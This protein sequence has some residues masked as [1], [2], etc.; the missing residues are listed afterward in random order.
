MFG[1]LP[2]K[3]RWITILMSVVSWSLSF[4]LFL[5]Y[6]NILVPKKSQE[7]LILFKGFL[8]LSVVKL[9]LHIFINISSLFTWLAFW[10]SRIRSKNG[11]VVF[12]K[13]RVCCWFLLLSFVHSLYV[14]FLRLL[15]NKKH[16]TQQPSSGTLW[17]ID[18]VSSAAGI[19]RLVV[20]EGNLDPINYHR[21]IVVKS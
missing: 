9:E 19:Y 4:S 11:T 17:L 18:K 20:R 14:C 6:K 13:H 21:Y 3:L 2:A 10:F 7:K 16:S 1:L 8:S 5:L 15:K 12:C